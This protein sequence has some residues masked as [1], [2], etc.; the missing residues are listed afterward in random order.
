MKIALIDPSLF[1]WPYDNALADGLKQNGHEV[2][3]YTK[4]LGRTEQGKNDPYILELFYPGFQSS[5][6]KRLPSKIFL[7]LKGICHIFSMIH[8]W[9]I[10]K[11]NKPDAIHFQW[12][13]LAIVD[14]F[15]IPAFRSIAPTIL[16][17][18]DSSPFNNNPSAKLQRIGAISIMA[19]FDHLIVHTEKAEKA[20]IGYGI[21]PAI[22]SRIPHGILDSIPEKS[23]VRA[24][25][26]MSTN[27]KV[28]LLLFGQ[29]K[30]Y[31]GTDVLIRALAKLPHATRNKCMLQV[32]GKPQMDMEP[33]FT[34]ARELGVD[35]AINWDLR[36]VDEDEIA[37]IF[38]AA[39]IMVMP[40]REIDASGVLMIALS[41]GRPIVASRIGLFAELLEDEKHG[42]LTPVDDV[43]ALAHALT[44]LIDDPDARKNAGEHVLSLRRS[45][46]DWAEIGR[47]TASLYQKHIQKG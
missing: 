7:V 33:L 4:H 40:Y 42:A 22:I 20:L 38:E 32:I 12:T 23:V 18:H 43:D 45:I 27:G 13:P 41:V 10:L 15:F 26:A 29:V 5:L 44:K 25:A 1:T 24:P 2:T 14:Q 17:V 6:A 35:S 39:D 11:L 16:T 36:F 30:P 31:K 28:N 47:R 21:N 19:K 9:F 34:L 37:G 46:P 8:L 3:L